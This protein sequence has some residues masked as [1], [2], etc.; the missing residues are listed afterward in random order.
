MSWRG[1]SSL[2][3]QASSLQCGLLRHGSAEGDEISL[4]NGETEGFGIAVPKQMHKPIAFL[5]EA[6]PA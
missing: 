1:W 2:G 3:A 5:L 4:R 6:L